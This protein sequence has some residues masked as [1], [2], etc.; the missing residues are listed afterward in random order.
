MLNLVLTYQWYD[1]ILSGE[2]KI[3]YRAMSKKW[4]RD[5][6]EK[7]LG[8]SQVRF[9]RGYTKESIIKHV[10]FIDLGSCPYEGWD[11]KYIRI[12]FN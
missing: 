2:K 4:T 8:I 10:Y 3:E 9:Q 1:L 7:R 11:D 12:Y 5:I 6:W